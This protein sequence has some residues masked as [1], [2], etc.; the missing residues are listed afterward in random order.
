M[1]CYYW[2][3][4]YPLLKKK[5]CRYKILY[6]LIFF[7]SMILSMIRF[8]SLSVATCYFFQISKNLDTTNEKLREISLLQNFSNAQIFKLKQ[9]ALHVYQGNI[10]LWKHWN[11]KHINYFFLF[12]SSKLSID[13][14]SKKFLIKF[15]CI[16]IFF[17]N[18]LVLIIF[19]TE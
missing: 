14:F 13:W 10:N 5:Y 11:T 9:R 2:K 4:K 18:V 12:L 6:Q 17:T 19:S 16:V 7:L 3:K 8:N 15:I 1:E